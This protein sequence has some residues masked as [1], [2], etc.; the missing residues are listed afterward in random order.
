MHLF[1]QLLDELLNLLSGLSPAEWEQPTVCA[2]WTVKEVAQHL[3]GGD[4]SILAR[5]RDGY[6]GS[7]KPIKDWF[8]LVSF[9]N[10]L[11]DSWV[12]ATGQ[13]S[14]RL[15]CDLLEFTGRQV[16]DY[17][18]GLDSDAMGGPVS[19]AGPGPAP[20]WLDLAREYTERWHHQQHIRDAVGRP[21]LKE[22]KFFA[23]VLDAF[24]R[25]WPHSYREVETQAGALISLTISGAAGGR[26]F[27]LRQDQG[28]Q[29]YL[30][31]AQTPDAEVAIPQ[32]VAWRLFTKGLTKAEAQVQTTISGNQRLGSKILDMVSIIA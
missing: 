26:W 16:C 4:M 7:N 19:W 3:L 15:L 18:Q 20:V 1:P 9:I 10:E 14:P 21:G 31:V 24:I 22:A 11:N 27:L 32:E 17:F 5:K 29:L 28:W 2:P 23:P 30:D 13:M 12:K 8:E 6:A 25:A